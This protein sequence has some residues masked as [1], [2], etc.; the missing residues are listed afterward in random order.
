LA[1]VRV[2]VESS[3]DYSFVVYDIKW[4]DPLLTATAD[5][6]ATGR[7]YGN[8]ALTPQATNTI[9]AIAVPAGAK[10][11]QLKATP[12]LNFTANSISQGAVPR[13]G[14]AVYPTLTA[15]ATFS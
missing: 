2:E 5:A 9:A 7:P 12:R 8:N 11:V 13:T 6:T 1:W 15:T 3:F 10:T 14:T 4:A